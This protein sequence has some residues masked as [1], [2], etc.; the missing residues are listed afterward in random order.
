MAVGVGEIRGEMVGKGDSSSTSGA[1]ALVKGMVKGEFESLSTTWVVGVGVGAPTVGLKVATASDSMV[2]PIRGVGVDGAGER[3]ISAP[4]VGAWLASSTLQAA[5]AKV[6][7]I[8]I[9]R[10]VGRR[11]G[12]LYQSKPCH[13]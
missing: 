1:G 4:T 11:I 13:R 6:A 9:N 2:G 10:R 7:R 5:I 3:I 8:D 12:V